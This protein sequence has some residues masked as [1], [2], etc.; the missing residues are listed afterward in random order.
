M[1]LTEIE[2]IEEHLEDVVLES[3]HLILLRRPLRLRFTSGLPDQEFARESFIINKLQ[4]AY[5]D[6]I[7][8]TVCAYNCND[9]SDVVASG[10]KV[11]YC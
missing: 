10:T 11:F 3:K 2:D 7:D 4:E 5:G 8:D 6:Y 9:Q 1:D